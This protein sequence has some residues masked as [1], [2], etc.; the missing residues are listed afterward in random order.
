MAKWCIVTG[1]S[2]DAYRSLT[3][4]ERDVFWRVSKG[5]EVI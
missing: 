4:V 1:Q 3:A 5:E 2:P